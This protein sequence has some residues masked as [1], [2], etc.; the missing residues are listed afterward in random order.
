MYSSHKFRVVLFLTAATLGISWNATA[1]T[2]DNTFDYWLMPAGLV[3]NV[4]GRLQ[5]GQ[6]YGPATKSQWRGVW[7]GKSV[8]LAA[9]SAAPYRQYD[10]F[11][12]EGTTLQYWTLFLGNSYP[13]E[14]TDSHAFAA[15]YTFLNKSMQV[16][17]FI[18]NS[19]TDQAYSA[20]FRKNLQTS[21]GNKR[22]EINAYYSTWQDP[23]TGIVWSDVLQITYWGAYSFA[24]PNIGKEIYWL[25]KGHGF[26]HFS[27]PTIDPAEEWVTSEFTAP[28]G[29]FDIPWYDPFN[30]STFVPNGFFEDNSGCGD[31]DITTYLQSWGAD[32]P[33]GIITTDGAIP[34]VSGGTGACKIALLS[35]VAISAWPTACIPVV[36]GATY[37]LS[38]WIWRVSNQDNAYIDFNDGFACSG[39]NFTD[40]QAVATS[41]NTWELREATV[42]VGSTTTGIS[43]RVVRDGAGVDNAYFD[44]VMLQRVN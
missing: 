13:P 37:K 7:A 8:A 19:N 9:G 33:R 40:N 17:E 14:G 26:V 1:Q 34:P 39:G 35:G 12:D 3:Q 27:S 15:P 44:G 30:T 25:A 16:G 42:T 2:I 20:Q 4:D 18:L 28:Q 32:S 24:N 5:N 11:S 36:P 29:A 6:Q 43:I 41:T 23:V 21:T 22:T 38:G 31:G 10:L